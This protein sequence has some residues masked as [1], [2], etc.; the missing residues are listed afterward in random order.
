MSDSNWGRRLA[1]AAVFVVVAAVAVRWLR[2]SR[3]D[4]DTGRAD[5]DAT[6]REVSVE[7]D[8]VSVG[9]NLSIAAGGLDPTLAADVLELNEEAAKLVDTAEREL[10]REPIETAT[11]GAVEVPDVEAELTDRVRE[12]DVSETAI[13]E[14][15][16]LGLRGV[17]DFGS[18]RRDRDD[19][20]DGE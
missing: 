7:L 2:G 15:E 18:R 19:G 20:T 16:R 14:L 5:G 4:A 17:L 12:S 11:G 9:E 6:D 1:L 8:E 3:S 10:V 13:D